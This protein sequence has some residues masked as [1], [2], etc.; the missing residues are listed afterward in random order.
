MAFVSSC[1]LFFSLCLCYSQFF[2]RHMHPPTPEVRGLNLDSQTR[3]FHYHG[4]ADIIAIKMKCC[5]IYYACKDCHDAFADHRLE[6]WPKSEWHTQAVLCGSCGSELT[7]SAYLQSNSRCPR[8]RAAFNPCC[9]NH[10]HLYFAV[11]PESP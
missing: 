3:C 9:C 1:L 7:I 2:V 11:P 5:G 8:C 10:Y 6:P 4:P